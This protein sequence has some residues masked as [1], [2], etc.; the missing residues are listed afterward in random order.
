MTIA[1]DYIG[2]LFA[3]RTVKLWSSDYGENSSEHHRRTVAMNRRDFIVTSVGTPVL[4]L[5]TGGSAGKGSPRQTGETVSQ[6]AGMSLRQL[7][8]RYRH[9]LFGNFLP[10]MDKYVID[11]KYGGFMCNTD[12]DGAHLSEKKEARFEGR[13]I[14][15]HSF[16]DRSFGRN[17]KYLE[18]AR[19]S[20]ALLMKSKPEGSN[21][22]WPSIF[23][24]EGKPHKR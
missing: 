6:L 21:S 2:L 1:R 18:V 9:D 11:H 10:F 15:V 24:R 22:L 13:G 23:D 14:R 20:V 7:R 17:P 4:G 3:R 5:A 19:R 12:R 16:L 8:D